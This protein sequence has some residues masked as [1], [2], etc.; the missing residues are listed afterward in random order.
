MEKLYKEL[1]CSQVEAIL[2]D[3]EN[4]I[5][6]YRINNNVVLM[7]DKEV[8]FSWCRLVEEDTEDEIEKN[9][10]TYAYNNLTY[11]DNIRFIGNQYD[12]SAYDYYTEGELISIIKEYEFMYESGQDEA[13]SSE[14]LFNFEQ[15]LT[16]KY[17]NPNN[18]V[19]DV[20][21]ELEEVT[22]ELSSVRD[23][24]K[25]FDEELGEYITTLPYYHYSI[26][27]DNE[28]NYY[29]IHNSHYQYELPTGRIM[30]QSK[31]M[32]MFGREL[33]EKS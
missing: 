22:E 6:R 18:V 27:K 2:L 9:F 20:I 17:Y 8:Y 1:N 14:D 12:I 15:V 26:Y 3:K 19:D 33:Q 31:L 7:K 16:Y 29:L 13:G 25:F 30:S 32:D 23:D 4:V 11:D 24:D 5:E 28:E 21:L 10:F